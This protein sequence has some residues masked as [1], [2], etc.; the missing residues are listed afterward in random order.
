M[1]KNQTIDLILGTTAAVA[2][3]LPPDRQRSARRMPGQPNQ[4]ALQNQVFASVDTTRCL[5]M[6]ARYQLQEAINGSRKAIY[7][8]QQL[9]AEADKLLAPMIGDQGG[10]AIRAP[11]EA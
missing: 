5:I 10:D 11:H 4:F 8:S 9:L 6:K 1:G 7:E 2:I 3:V